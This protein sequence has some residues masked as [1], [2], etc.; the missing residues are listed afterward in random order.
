M[1]RAAIALAVFALGAASAVA[2]SIDNEVDFETRDLIAE[3]DARDYVDEVDARELLEE[4]S[5]VDARD[6]EVFSDLEA[7]EVEEVFE[8]LRDVSA[9]APTKTVT[10]THTKSPKATA[11]SKKELKTLKY[12]SRVSKARKTLLAAKSEKPKSLRGKMRVRAAKKLLRNHLKKKAASK[13]K[14]ARKSRRAARKARK[15]ALKAA[16]SPSAPK[17]TGSATSSSSPSKITPPPKK[18]KKSLFKK[19]FGKKK[20]SKKSKDT[21]KVG[22]DGVTTVHVTSTAAGATCSAPSSFRKKYLK[23][24]ELDEDLMEVFEREN[25]FDDL[26]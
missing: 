20:S 10:V 15:A 9:D 1:V 5:D 21:K 8:Y 26:D 17:A 4:Y 2:Q 6:P 7:R 3:V 22:K 19:L 25:E 12:N 11:C 16:A 13:R 24:R 14:S 23:S 18:E